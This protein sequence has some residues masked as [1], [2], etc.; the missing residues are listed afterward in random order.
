MRITI[1][2][3]MD[4]SG[5][6]GADNGMP[7]RLPADLRHFKH[8]TLGKPVLMGR[9][10]FESI[11]RPLPERLNLVLTRDA[12]FVAPGCRVVHDVD[13]ALA[14]AADAP[15]LMVIGG[16]EVYR[17]FLPCADRI[18]LTRVHDRFQGDTWFPDPVLAGWDEVA[19]EDY[20][21]DEGNPHAYSF[22][23]LERKA[24]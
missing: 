13:D 23:V 9:R 7:W 16:A 24:E 11:G 22:C 21:A 3:A 20:P 2:V 5:L 17:M 12:A 15:E 8:T 14:A 1:V 6:I 18:E 4:E 10:T 19:R